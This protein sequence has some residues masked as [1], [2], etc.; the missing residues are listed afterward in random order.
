MTVLSK[1]GKDAFYDEIG[2]D[3]PDK[4]YGSFELARKEAPVQFCKKYSVKDP[5]VLIQGCF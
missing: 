5:Q 1:L 4:N 2:I 3:V